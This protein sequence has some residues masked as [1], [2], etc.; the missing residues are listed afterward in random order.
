MKTNLTQFFLLSTILIF[1]LSCGKEDSNNEKEEETNEKETVEF[2]ME[3]KV[4]GELVRTEYFVMNSNIY[5]TINNNCIIETRK[6]SSDIRGWNMDLEYLG[7]DS[8]SYPINLKYDNFNNIPRIKSMNYVDI[9]NGGAGTYVLDIYKPDQLVLTLT[10]WEDEILEG[11]FSGDLKWNL[12][13]TGDS[14]ITFTEGKFK[15]P[16]RRIP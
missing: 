16:M 8:L 12:S 9:P 7:L 4:N 14:T 10:K 6:S 3:A 13:S 15:I 2:Y 5:N 1:L 11:T